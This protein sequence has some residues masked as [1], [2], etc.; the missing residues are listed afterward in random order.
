MTTDFQLMP[1]WNE[2]LRLFDKCETR[3]EESATGTYGKLH[4]M[5]INGARGAVNEV[6]ISVLESF[7]CT[8]FLSWHHPCRQLEVLVYIQIPLPITL[9]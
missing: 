6:E 2:Y 9:T 8:S 4:L 7:D 5:T 3:I 1:A